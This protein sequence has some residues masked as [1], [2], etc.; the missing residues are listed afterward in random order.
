MQAQTRKKIAVLCSTDYN[1]YPVGGMMSFIKDAAPALSQRFDVDFW[2]VDA[3]S[4]LD[5]F[6]SGGEDFPVR[7]FANVR[8]GRKL[9]PNLV[10]VTW[11]LRR[12]RAA[13][14]S[15]GYDALYIHGAPLNLALPAS[16]T[17]KRINHLHGPNNPLSSIKAGFLIQRGAVT[18]YERVRKKAVQESDLVIL[19][20]DKEGLA[21]FKDRYPTQK[22][23]VTLPNFCD[24]TTFN[25]GVLPIEKPDANLDADDRILLFVGRLSRE[26]DP[27]L[28]VGSWQGSGR[29]FPSPTMLNWW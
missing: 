9:I 23:I 13:L 8:T 15:E 4:G 22:M 10:R 19:A 20:A 27:L 28:A 29:T 3:G 14:L 6:T 16:A 26:K 18:W 17:P 5:S 21:P 1:T 11:Q 25:I 12:N 24:T 2:G 7:F